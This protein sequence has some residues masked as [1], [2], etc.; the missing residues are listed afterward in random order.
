[1]PVQQGGVI[2][3]GH[4]AAWA[5]NDVIE[6]AGTATEPK[7]NS[8][9]LYGNGG[10]PLGITNSAYAWPFTGPYTT[11]GFGVSQTAAYINTYGSQNLPFQIQVNGT[12]QASFTSSSVNFAQPLSI[13]SGGTGLT[14]APSNGQ[15]LIGNNGGYSL[16]TL[17]AGSGI[18]INNTAGNIQ[19]T[20]TGTVA[21]SL[22]VGG[23]PISSGTNGAF[24]Y[25]NAGVLANLGTIGTAGSVVLSNG[26]TLNSPTLVTPNLGV[27]SS[28]N[29]TN[30]VALPASALPTPNTSNVYYVSTAG[31]DSNNG[32]SQ[33]APFL[34]LQHAVTAASGG[35][36]VIVEGGTYSLT[37]TLNMASGVT[38][39]G[40]YGTV[41]TQPNSTGLSAIISCTGANNC[42]ILNLVVDGNSA[43]NSYS[44]PTLGINVDS[45]NDCYIQ[46]CTIRNTTNDAIR[47]TNGLRAHVQNNEISNVNGFAAIK[48][49]PLVAQTETNHIISGNIITAPTGSHPILI[50]YGDGDIVSDNIIRGNLI[51]GLKVTLVSGSTTATATTGTFSNVVPGYYLIVDASSVGGP[52][53]YELFVVAV[54]S[55]TTVTLVAASSYNITSA[56]AVAG[57][58]DMISVGAASRI[59]IANNNI[60]GG[61][62]GGITVSDEYNIGGVY[63]SLQMIQIAN[64]QTLNFANAG[65]SIQTGTVGGSAAFN[66]TITGNVVTNSG[67]GG[68][69]A[70]VAGILIEVGTDILKSTFIDS[71]FVWDNQGTPTTAYWMATVGS[72]A[73][74]LQIFVGKNTGG[75]VTGLIND[76]IYNGATYSISGWG[77]GA[78]ISN[79]VSQGSS[80]K[81]TLTTGTSPSANPTITLNTIATSTTQPPILISKIVADG[82][83]TFG[84]LY[85]EQNANYG[86]IYLV[87]KGTPPA[88]TT[89]IINVVS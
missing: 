53:A 17:T 14:A 70:P 52:S 69:G 1:V 59:V 31:S 80:Y 16:N 30:A 51:T 3:P 73:T 38:L 23:S 41:I 85:G 35:G 81:F 19:I 49:L 12:I 54:T 78:A 9:G 2:T 18:N 57:A 77:S 76:G 68:T 67:V 55:P 40:N 65:I 27:P 84:T 22:V 7:L 32:L 15:L 5:I 60:S 47:I 26:P 56:T 82:S 66:N 29:L 87:Y 10:T 37:S 8:L 62:G 39:Q 71:N 83:G 50:G 75:T 21:G 63:E 45:G 25:N 33:F 64:N 44:S 13:S 43:N 36:T 89:L 6:D 74:E 48:V 11:M 42:R 34:T 4:A 20:A 88:S 79:F 24:L 58:G 72:L 46:N 61:A 86:F 28:I